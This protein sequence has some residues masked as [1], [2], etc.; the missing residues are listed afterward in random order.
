LTEV[1][2]RDV[3]RSGFGCRLRLP[4]LEIFESRIGF[5]DVEEV[6]DRQCMGNIFN[7]EPFQTN[8]MVRCPIRYPAQPDGAELRYIPIEKQR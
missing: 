7:G 8:E 1:R 5:E 6:V 4:Q 2:K 3:A